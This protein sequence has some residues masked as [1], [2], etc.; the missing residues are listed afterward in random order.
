MEQ[1][2]MERDM[3]NRSSSH[4]CKQANLYGILLAAELHKHRALELARLLLHYTHT[5][6]FMDELQSDR[7]RNKRTSNETRLKVN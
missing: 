7:V 6:K 3:L 1:P 5:K 2:N 4:K